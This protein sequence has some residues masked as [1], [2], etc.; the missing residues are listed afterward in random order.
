MDYNTLMSMG[1]NMQEIQN[2]EYVYNNGGKFTPAALQSYGYTYAQANRL[3]YLFKV[4]TGKVDVSSDVSQA[5]HYKKMFGNNYKIGIQNLGTN[6]V[7]EVPRV[8]V[9]AN[10]VDAPYNIWNSN[11]YK[12]KD[13]FYKVVDVT[14]KKITVETAKK[15]QLQWGKTKKLDGILEIKGVKSNGNAVV[16]FDKNYCRLCNRYAIVAS[17]KRPVEHLG[18]YEMLCFE[19]T[20]VYVFAKNMG[21]GTNVGLKGATQRVYDYGLI[22]GSIK[23]KLTKITKDV[24]TNLGGVK[25]RYEEAN[26]TYTMIPRD[27]PEE[28]ED[29]TPD[30]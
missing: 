3:A 8:A 5:K 10:I 7:V 13:I 28:S 4:Y 6:R 30:W 19:G 17:L 27:I 23:N 21:T 12:G 22:P 26:S 18:M 25:A 11:N 2:M 1:F 16:T 14:G 20:R 29:M 15:P 9:V 24:Y